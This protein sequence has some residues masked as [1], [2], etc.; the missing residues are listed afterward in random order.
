MA[1]PL[2]HWSCD[3]SLERSRV[4]DMFPRIS[5]QLPSAQARQKVLQ[6]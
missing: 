2:M 5:Q 1:E 4:T 6:G 3:W